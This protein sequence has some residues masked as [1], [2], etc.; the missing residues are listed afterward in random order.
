MKENKE[1]NPEEAEER[2][3]ETAWKA[4]ES[5]EDTFEETEDIPVDD[6]VEEVDEPE[7]EESKSD[8]PDPKKREPEQ[9]EAA[10]EQPDEPE[11]ESDSSKEETSGSGGPFRRKEKKDKKD[12]QIEELNDRVRRQMAEFDNYRKRTEKEKSQMFETGAKSVI[13]KMLPVIDNFER[14]LDTI[15]EEEKDGAFA[16]G[17]NKIYRQLMA[18]LDDLD[19]KP[20]EAEGLEFDPNLHNAVMHV[21]DE[22]LGENI[23]VEELQKGYTYGDSVVRHSMVKVAN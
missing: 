5:E 10:E 4:V 1:I 17:M 2:K 6:S 9:E 16:D 21:D 11:K 18:V 14:G 23:V 13:E 8:E 20:I 7:P 3:D 12:E 19:V 22:D 15:P